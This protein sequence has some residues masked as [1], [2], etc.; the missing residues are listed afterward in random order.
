MSVDYDWYIHV[1]IPSLKRW[2]C[3]RNFRFSYRCRGNDCYLEWVYT[4]EEITK[5]PHY[6]APVEF[7][8]ANGN[9]VIVDPSDPEHDR[10]IFN[11][12]DDNETECILFEFGSA[13]T[14]LYDV[15]NVECFDKPFVSAKESIPLHYAN[16]ETLELEDYEK[17][18]DDL[19]FVCRGMAH[20]FEN[21]RKLQFVPPIQILQEEYSFSSLK[22]DSN[23][24]SWSKEG[25]QEKYRAYWD[26]FLSR[27]FPG[28]EDVRTVVVS[29]LPP[30]PTTLVRV[31]ENISM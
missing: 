14:S 18:P 10:Y 23:W 28:Q 15:T 20:I 9:S 12:E 8:F 5:S 29:F 21:A 6:S 13:Q 17:N 22:D 27:L 3:L 4:D 31:Q 24:D 25:R 19:C 26:I 30:P 2:I 11:D 7:Q 1:Y 16:G